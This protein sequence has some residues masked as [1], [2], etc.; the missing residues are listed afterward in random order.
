MK[1]QL[2]TYFKRLEAASSEE[3]S[4]DV[5]AE[6]QAYYATLS[7]VQL[8]EVKAIL[9]PDIDQLKEELRGVD[10]AIESTFARYPVGRFA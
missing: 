1:E 7:E 10:E 3:E 6:L 8:A 4:Q 5:A 9:K 2:N